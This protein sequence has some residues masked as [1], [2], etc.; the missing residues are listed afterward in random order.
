M[1]LHVIDFFSGCGGTSAGFQAAGMD[2]LCG[3][4]F[5]EKALAT[6]AA[7]IQKSV[8]IPADVRDLEPEDIRRNVDVPDRGLVVAACAPC[9]PFSKQNS[10]VYDSDKDERSDLIGELERFV[11]DFMPDY[12][13]LENVPGLENHPQSPYSRFKVFL[14]NLEYVCSGD[15]LNA[16]DFGVAQ[17]RKRL[18]MVASRH[19]ELRLP[20]PT[21]GKDRKKHVSVNS[22]LDRFPPIEAGETHPDFPNH[23]SAKLHP[24]NLERIRAT[25]EGGDWRDWPEALRLDC[26]ANVNG[27]TDTYGRMDGDQPCRT[28]TTRCNSYSNGRFGHPTQDRAISGREAAALQSFPDDFVFVGTLNDTARQVG[29]AVPVL[30]AE[31]IGRAIV[32]HWD[33]VNG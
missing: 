20:S 25:P 10:K 19:G 5:D 9:Q 21:H 18:V 27:Y 15:V 33:S 29:N 28:L 23:R 31:A 1:A 3:I 6:Y 30:F 14:E 2:V 26:H 12:I 17:F 8:P 13:V 22:V 16:A 7:N 11:L 4:D 32:N 24:R